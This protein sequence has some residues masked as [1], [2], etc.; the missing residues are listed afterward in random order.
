MID[1]VYMTLRKFALILCR[2]TD[3]FLM[4]WFVATVATEHATLRILDYLALYKLQDKMNS[5]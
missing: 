3:V 1:V 4:L 5:V 2:Y